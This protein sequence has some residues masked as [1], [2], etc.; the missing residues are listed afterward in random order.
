MLGHVR[1]PMLTA[2]AAETRGTRLCVAHNRFANWRPMLQRFA[3]KL[4][5]LKSVLA[6]AT[7]LSNCQVTA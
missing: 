3:P 2:K 5:Q 6:T 1:N 4:S 7:M